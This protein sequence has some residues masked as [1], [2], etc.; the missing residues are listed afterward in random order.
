M[1]PLLLASLGISG[2]GMLGKLFSGFGSKSKLQDLQSQDPTYTANPLAAQRMG[3]AQTLL[4]ARMPGGTNLERNIY[5]NEANQ[6]AN[7]NRNATDGSQALALGAAAQGQSNQAFANLGTQEQ[8]DYYNRLGNLSSAQQGQIQE[9]DKVYQDRVRRYDD[10]AAILGAQLN[11]N[12]TSWNSLANMGIGGAGLVA[13]L[14]G[15]NGGRTSQPSGYNAGY[16]FMGMQPQSYGQS[17]GVTAP[18][19][20]NPYGSND[21]GASQWPMQM[22]Y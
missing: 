7:V 22:R 20:I 6:L 21:Q 4:N 12:Q 5:G 11:N 13:Q 2:I 14:G 19:W 1:N 18:S 3:L 16:S 9:G 8:Q 17:S 15:Q 10:Q